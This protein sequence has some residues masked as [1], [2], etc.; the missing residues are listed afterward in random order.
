MEPLCSAGLAYQ[1]WAIACELPVAEILPW[2][3]PVTP[4]ITLRQLY[5]QS[6]ISRLLLSA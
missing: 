1:A 3:D 6:C 2:G 4:G 5:E